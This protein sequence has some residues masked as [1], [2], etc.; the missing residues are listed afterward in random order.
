MP[1][2][3]VH[4]IVSATMNAAAAAN[5]GRQR[6][7]SHSNSGN[8]RAIG[9]KVAHDSRG[10]KILIALVAVIATSAMAPSMAS[11]CGGGSRTAA[12]TPINSGATV[13]M[14]SASDANQ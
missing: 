14:P 2:V 13:T 7:A 8:S 5:T 6:A 3:V 12:A 4:T 9:T 10:R 1:K 11:L